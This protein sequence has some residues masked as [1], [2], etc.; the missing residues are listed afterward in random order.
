MIIKSLVSDPESVSVKE[1]E[2]E[3]GILIE[4]VVNE[5]EAGAIIGKS[6]KIA[7]SIRTIVQ[8]SSNLKDRKKVKINITTL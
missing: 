4:V 2:E 6:G 7:N 3:D 1:F 8:A 5:E